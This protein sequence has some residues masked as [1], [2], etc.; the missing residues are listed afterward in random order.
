MLLFTPPGI[1]LAI[2]GTTSFFVLFFLSVALSLFFPVLGREEIGIASL[3]QKSSAAFSTT[4]QPKY[5]TARYP[6][7]E[8]QKQRHLA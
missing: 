2:S 7:H 6:F 5:N 1:V 8:W 3:T 4:W